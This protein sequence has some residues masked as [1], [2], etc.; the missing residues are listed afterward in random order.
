MA[1][2]Y[3]TRRSLGR[4]GVVLLVLLLLILLM[5]LCWMLYMGRYVVYTENGIRFDFDRS[6]LDITGQPAEP[7]AE[8]EPI[9]IYMNEGEN[10]VDVNQE[11]T[12]LSGYYISTAD[13][14]GDLEKLEEQILQL[15]PEMAIMVEVKSIR[16][17]FNYATAVGEYYNS[18]VDQNAVEEFLEK[19]N[20][21]G[22]YVIASVPAFQDRQY[23]LNNVN[24]GLF[25]TKGAFLYMDDEGC[26]WLNPSSDKVISY[27]A[28][29]GTELRL[30]GFDEVVFDQF[31]FPESDSYRFS[32]TKSQALANAAATLADTCGTKSFAVSFVSTQD[33]QLPEGRCRLYLKNVDASR[34]D[35][36]MDAVTVPDLTIR[37]VFLTE[38]HDTRY[39][40]CGALRP[41][42]A[43]K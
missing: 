18:K 32:G 25:S 26:Y 43:M 8:R 22:R 3:R 27:L 35:N 13:L 11:L 7:P 6:S 37:L 38:Y 40:E 9:P 12:Q 39:D 14:E 36:V 28:Q 1:I 21:S 17:E 41:I 20:R 5:M 19:L 33:L 29:I 16:G 24:E 30:M 4:F 2:P 42:T 10:A 31:L 15:P 23:G 34:V